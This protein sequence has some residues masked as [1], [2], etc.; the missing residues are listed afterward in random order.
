MSLRN[1]FC[2]QWELISE[3]PMN[4]DN[5]YTFIRI[6]DVNIFFL[7]RFLINKP[8]LYFIGKKYYKFATLTVN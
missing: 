1:L 5:L 6:C 3:M 2:S 4:T 7:F 8:N